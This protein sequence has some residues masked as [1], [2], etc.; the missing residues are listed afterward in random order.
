MTLEDKIAKYL[1]QPGAFITAAELKFIDAMREAAKN[2]VGYGWMQQH[3]EWEWQDKT[4][5]PS[6]GPEYFKKKIT[7]LEKRLKRKAHG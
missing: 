6:W 1:E 7:E 2:G 3:I 4:A 5:G